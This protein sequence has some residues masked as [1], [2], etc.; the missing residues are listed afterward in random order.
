MIRKCAIILFI[1]LVF[2]RIVLAQEKPREI[3]VS[4]MD[5]LCQKDQ[6][7]TTITTDCINTCSDDEIA[8]NVFNKQ[9]YEEKLSEC[10]ELNNV[11]DEACT[12]ARPLLNLNVNCVHL[13]CAV[14][15]GELK[16]VPNLKSSEVRKLAD[17]FAIKNKYDLSEYKQPTIRFRVSD[18]SWIVNY[19]Q[20]GT[21]NP[22]TG[23]IMLAAGKFF[24]VDIN[25]ETKEIN[26]LPGE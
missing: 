9:N 6:D 15:I 17:D 7:C 12:L 1:V 23:Q 20:R 24:T 10:R 25:D 16:D 5:Q 21:L 14:T 2:S 22:Q 4:P 18:N 8:V 13:E 3:V 26:L 19:D 11:K